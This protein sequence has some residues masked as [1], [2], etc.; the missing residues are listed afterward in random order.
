MIAA[1]SR[2]AFELALGAAF[3]TISAAATLLAALGLARWLDGRAP[4]VPAPAAAVAAWFRTNR[5]GWSSA[6]RVLGT[7]RFALLFGAAATALALAFDPRY[8][9]FPLAFAAPPAVALAALAWAAGASAEVEER[10]L[11]AVLVAAAPAIVLREGLANTD[12]LAWAALCLALAASVWRMSARG[13]A[14]REHQQAGERPD[15]AGGGRVQH[16]PRGAE[17]SGGERP[18]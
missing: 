17:A 5:S 4:L 9:D 10:A 8:R 2:D 13:D 18:G 3:G 11:A 1:A 12:A 15:G 14:P 16:E 7:L 6:E